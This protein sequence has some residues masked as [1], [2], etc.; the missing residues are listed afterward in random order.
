M[1]P[2]WI[3]H[4][5]R[6]TAMCEMCNTKK[7]K[8]LFICDCGYHIC[9]GCKA[10]RDSV[11]AGWLHVDLD[12]HPYGCANPAPND[13]NTVDA[14]PSKRKTKAKG[15]A[16]TPKNAESTVTSSRAKQ[17]TK[18]DTRSKTTRTSTVAE[19][20]EGNADNSVT[21]AGSN[22][23]LSESEFEIET[24]SEDLTE[25][26]SDFEN[27]KETAANKMKGKAKAGGTKKPT[28]T[29]APVS[30]NPTRIMTSQNSRVPNW[31]E[32]NLNQIPKPNEL[33]SLPRT[34]RDDFHRKY[35][36]PFADIGASPS[37]PTR[38]HEYPVAAPLASS[39]GPLKPW[40]KVEVDRVSF[41]RWAD[42]KKLGA[43]PVQILCEDGNPIATLTPTPGSGIRWCRYG[44][45]AQNY[46]LYSE[47]RSTGPIG[48]AEPDYPWVNRQ[49]LALVEMMPGAWRKNLPEPQH[50]RG[51]PRV[52]LKK[53]PIHVIQRPTEDEVDRAIEHASR[54]YH[55]TTSDTGTPDASKTTVHGVSAQSSKAL[56]VFESVSRQTQSLTQEQQAVIWN[57]IR[58]FA[59]KA[60]EAATE[61][62]NTKARRFQQEQD[63]RNGLAGSLERI[64]EILKK[65]NIRPQDAMND[66]EVRRL[67]KL[68]NQKTNQTLGR[69]TPL[70]AIYEAFVVPSATTAAPNTTGENHEKRRR[71]SDPPSAQPLKKL[72]INAPRLGIEAQ[73]SR[74]SPLSGFSKGIDRTLIDSGARNAGVVGQDGSSVQDAE[75][76][77]GPVAAA[78]LQMTEK[79][80]ALRD[81]QTTQ[82][83]T[84]SGNPVTVT[85]RRG[86]TRI[87]PARRLGGGGNP[88]RSVH[89]DDAEKN[90]EKVAGSGLSASRDVRTI[91][92]TKWKAYDP[93][94][95]VDK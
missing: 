51:L 81:P 85:S 58:D 79:H 15:R 20:C 5:N 46:F 1:A 50:Q 27:V 53:D 56:A 62:R 77:K 6:A 84:D 73:T 47:M 83:A 90:V 38:P 72:R 71:L 64:A 75:S 92:S 87:F 63:D 4:T 22:D 68:L 66:P 45:N 3:K 40:H 65:G 59:A 78:A 44:D 39:T 70:P 67:S 82:H 57:D 80:H 93:N 54:P 12:T 36:N 49:V 89:A 94:K 13:A 14:P 28:Q 31:S 37:R 11:Q 33:W 26:L 32:L 76:T 17:A 41:S 16:D 69:Q 95:G 86:G 25:I 42:P 74:Q 9:G 19:P 48:A 43:H 8:I 60:I 91:A 23:A 24:G 21:V 61:K 7:H 88:P 18:Q 34:E 52:N 29:K 35:S 30:S 2:T 55:A 10:Q